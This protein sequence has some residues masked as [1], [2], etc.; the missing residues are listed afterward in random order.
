[1]STLQKD[2]K[3]IIH[4]SGRISKD[5]YSRIQFF[6][7]RFWGHGLVATH[8][9]LENLWVTTT[10]VVD[11]LL[12]NVALNQVR[13]YGIKELKELEQTAYRDRRNQIQQFYD[14]L[15]EAR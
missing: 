10:A 4:P 15:K 13:D 11:L 9:G 5:P 8:E 6:E 14:H 2:E 12:N 1:I 7:R 3:L